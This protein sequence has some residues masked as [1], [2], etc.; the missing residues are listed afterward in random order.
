MPTHSEVRFVPY[1]AEEI[2]E[3]VGD[4]AKYPD[5]LPWCSGAR[6]RK[7]EMIDGHKV[8]TADLIIAYK[9][10]REKFSSKVTL[11]PEDLKVDISY[12]DGPFKYLNSYWKVRPLEDG[13]E[14]DFYVDFEF[15]NR[16]L[17]SM[18]ARIFTKAVHKMVSAFID[19]ADVLYG[20]QNTT[21]PK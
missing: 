7:E 16:L 13:S 20:S 11:Y 17:Q 15:K 18:V 1:A 12:Q 21:E 10:F 3:M 5:F 14:I 4:I 8:I 19:R 9:V 6:I 2:F